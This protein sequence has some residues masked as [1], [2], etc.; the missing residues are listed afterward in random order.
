MTNANSS[1]H[2]QLGGKCLHLPEAQN[3]Y[4]S[5]YTIVPTYIISI[6]SGR[7]H[8]NEA[9]S[10]LKY[11]R[12]VVLVLPNVQIHR[13][14]SK[15]YLISLTKRCSPEKPS[16]QN[17]FRLRNLAQFMLGVFMGGNTKGG[18]KWEGELQRETTKNTRGKNKLNELCEICVCLPFR[19]L[20]SSTINDNR[21]KTKNQATRDTWARDVTG[22]WGN[23]MKYIGNKSI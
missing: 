20:L 22:Y 9:S 3:I 17:N 2:K 11:P 21:L 18:G 13:P 16:H 14:R 7:A 1:L 15:Y 10:T 4:I 6:P 23:R 5:V 12:V 8:A 19:W